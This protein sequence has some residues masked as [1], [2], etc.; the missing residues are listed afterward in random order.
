MGEGAGGLGVEGNDPIDRLELALGL[1]DEDAVNGAGC[2]RDEVVSL[3]GRVVLLV[4][5][6]PVEVAD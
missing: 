3:V 1:D 5:E 2:T 4:D 6:A